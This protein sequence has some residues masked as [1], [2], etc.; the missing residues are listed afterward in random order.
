MLCL[1][2]LTTA[3]VLRLGENTMGAQL[4][5]IKIQGES[6]LALSH[7]A[8]K[9]FQIKNASGVENTHKL[10]CF[11]VANFESSLNVKDRMTSMQIYEAGQ[12]IIER[13]THE[14]LQDFIMAFKEAKVSGRKFYN[15]L[16]I[17]DIFQIITEYLEKKSFFLEETNRAADKQNDKYLNLE[18]LRNSYNDI[19]RNGIPETIKEVLDKYEQRY[20][21][22]SIQYAIKKSKLTAAVETE[23]TTEQ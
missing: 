23:T 2:Q 12:L 13:Y 10:V 18:Q 6:T 4:S 8:P 19:K 7:V 14:S 15:R 3:D 11:L 22:F 9:V 1:K 20:R 16:T 17:S 21:D 5:L